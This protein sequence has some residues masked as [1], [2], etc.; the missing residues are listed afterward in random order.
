MPI[1]VINEFELTYLD[2]IDQQILIEWNKYYR[3]MSSYL[4][5][6]IIMREGFIPATLAG[7]HIVRDLKYPLSFLIPYSDRRRRS[8]IELTERIHE[9]WVAVRIIREFTLEK[10]ELEVLQS[11]QK[12]LAIFGD[13]ALWLE[14]DFTP[15]KMCGGVIWRSQ[16]SPS[17]RLLEVYKRLEKCMPG[18]AGIRPD[19]IITNA[20]TCE[21]IIENPSIKLLIE[22]K[23]TSYELWR[24][25]IAKQI[26]PYKQILQPEHVLVVSMKPVPDSEKK[27]LKL[28]GIDVIDNVYLG[29]SG[30]LELAEYVKFSLK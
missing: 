29:G 7:L 18:R 25:D 8:C 3:Q 9:I 20:K 30:E 11:S 27:Q 16:I 28:R 13:Y 22:C 19:I 6:E 17:P 10:I 5:R 26:L 12:P 21:E 14:F 24:E 4:R 15:Q 2:T 23:N 1:E